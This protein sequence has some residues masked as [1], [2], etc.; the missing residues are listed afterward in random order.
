MAQRLDAKPFAIVG[1]NGDFDQQTAKAAA[2]THGMTW[3]SFQ[4]KSGGETISVAWHVW[5]WPTFYLIDQKGIIRKRWGATK[6]EELSQAIDQ[7]ML[8]QSQ[9]S[10]GL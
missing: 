8:E 4:N 5:S 7:L 6:P 10:P 1:V 3:R 9:S 2:A